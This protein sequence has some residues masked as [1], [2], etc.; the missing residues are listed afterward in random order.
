MPSSR[1]HWTPPED[2]IL[3]ELVGDVPSPRLATHYNHQAS[4]QG[5]PKR[6]HAALQHRAQSLGLSLQATGRWITPWFIAETIKRHPSTVS[7]WFRNY[8]TPSQF[9]AGRCLYIRRAELKPWARKHDRLLAGASRTDLFFLLEDEDL[10]SAIAAI[11]ANCTT[12]NRP[13]R[14]RLENGLTYPSLRSAARAAGV[15]DAGMVKAIRAGRATVC[16]VRFEVVR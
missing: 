10:A 11:P 8:P 5:L 4:C 13:V 1:T 12:R 15:S 3:V 9:R 16:G 2:Q 6:S 14:C 7:H